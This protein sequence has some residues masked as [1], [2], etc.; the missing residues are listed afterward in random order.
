MIIFGI[1]YWNIYEYMC[2]YARMIA[3]L[4]VLWICLFI[5]DAWELLTLAKNILD[6]S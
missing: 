1:I 6:N 5:Y 2:M 3:L 4:P